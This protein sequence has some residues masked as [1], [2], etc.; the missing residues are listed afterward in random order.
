MRGF[1]NE[2]HSCN[3]CA[4]SLLGNKFSFLIL[5][6]HFSCTEC[7]VQMVLDKIGSGQV[8]KIICPVADCNHQLSDMDIKNLGLSKDILD[9]YEEFSLRDAINQMDDMSWC[10]IPSCG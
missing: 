7:M 6:N 10:P 3:I 9:K 2:E 1:E 5:C 4:R 8:S